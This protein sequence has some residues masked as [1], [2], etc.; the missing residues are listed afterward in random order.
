METIK[1][2]FAAVTKDVSIDVK[3]ARRVHNYE[4]AFVNR[5]EDHVAFFGSPLQGVHPMRFR[6]SD[7]EA[8]FNDVLEIDELTLEDGI[9]ALKSIDPEWKRA[10]DVMNHSCIWLLYAIQHS[11]KLSP[12]QKQEA[13][14]NTLLVL[15]YKFLGSMMA[16]FYPYPADEATMLAVYA[17]MS[18]KYALKV[19]GSWSNLLRSRAQEILSPRSIHHRTIREF[20]DDKAVIYM[21]SD[22]QGRLRE[23]VKSVNTLFYDVRSRGGKIGTEKWTEGLSSIDGQEVVKDKKRKFSTHIRYLHEVIGD[24]NSFIRDELVKVIADA[25]HTMPP[26]LLVETLEW[27]SANHRVKGAEEVEELID[28]TLIYAFDLIASNRSLLGSRTGLTPLLVKLRSLYMASRMSDPTLLRTKELS[29][30]IVTQAVKSKNSSVIASVRTGTQLYLVLRS[31]AMS[32]YQ[33]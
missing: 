18:R 27:M 5:N 26:R 25:M 31:L 13:G 16:H 24:K 22:I 21:I 20:G 17:E 30:K 4:R 14:I 1:S 2:V 23:I 3:L 28:E 19:A 33:N 32:Y 6:T 11:S 15:Q 7:R 9:H 8:W 12:S 29:E 10:N